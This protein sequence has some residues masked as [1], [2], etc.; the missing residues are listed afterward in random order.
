MSFDLNLEGYNVTR[1]MWLKF[2]N[3]KKGSFSCKEECNGSV[4]GTD[5]FNVWSMSI[6]VQAVV[7][8]ARIFPK[9]LGPMIDPC[10]KAL[11][12]YRSPKHHGYTAGEYFE[13]NDDIYYDDDAQVASAIITAYE[14]TGKKEY[15]D[16]GRDLVRFLMGGDLS[17]ANVK[18]KGGMLWHIKQNY[19][20]S[21][22][23]AETALAALR[24]AQF[25]PSEAKTYYN[26]AKNLMNWQLDMLQDGD[27]LIGDGVGKDSTSPKMDKWSYNQGTTISALCMLYE[28]DHD[29]KWFSKATDIADTCCWKGSAV[30]CRD[31][32]DHLR[33]WRDP[34]YFIQLLIEGLA[35][36]MLVFEDKA[37]DWV[38]GKIREEIKRHIEF[39]R[40][41]CYDESDG[42]YYQS[43]DPIGISEDIWKKFASEFGDSRKFSPNQQERAGGVDGHLC[44]SLIGTGSAARVFFQAARVLPTI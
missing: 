41:Y 26:C 2:W 7:D 6:G 3:P 38:K 15:L 29:E 21:C 44:K 36:Y 43:F 24:L 10:I 8:G 19:V 14:V 20:N 16:A 13:G 1:N 23:T 17:G 40:K 22:T 4:A 31:Y 30:Y 33:Y 25:I 12:K 5:C 27:K 11:Y 32:P 9:D 42:L 37:S 39:F 18:C 34:S 28:I 35:D